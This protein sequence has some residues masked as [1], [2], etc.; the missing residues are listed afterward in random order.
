M[1]R[2]FLIKSSLTL[3]SQTNAITL[4]ESVWTNKLLLRWHRWWVNQTKEQH[5][6]KQNKT[7]EYIQQ[8]LREFSNNAT[9][10][11]WCHR[12]T[13]RRLFD[14]HFSVTTGAFQTLLAEPKV[15]TPAKRR[16]F[17]PEWVISHS[18]RPSWDLGW[19]SQRGGGAARMSVRDTALLSRSK[20]EAIGG[21]YNFLK[22]QP[23]TVCCLHGRQHPAVT[24]FC[25]CCC[26][27]P[28]VFS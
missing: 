9:H 12:K 1:K 22:P 25:C 5:I 17:T 27:F 26:F 19:V 21:W 24:R 28:E 6:K 10:W 20:D 23:S 14:F 18:D 2:R 11:W 16:W 7:T 3:E 15:R 8:R 13:C 4:A